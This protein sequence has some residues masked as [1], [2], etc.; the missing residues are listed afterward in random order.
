MDKV[1]KYLLCFFVG[2]LLAR[3]IGNGFSVGGSRRKR[4]RK[5]RIKQDNPGNQ[6]N[7]SGIKSL[8]DYIEKIVN[9]EK[10]GFPSNFDIKEGI[11]TGICLDNTGS[12]AD[13]QEQKT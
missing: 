7:C 12:A 13:K 8:D 2:F 11:V 10:G 6:N 4:T 5:I 1:V 3:M 9:Q